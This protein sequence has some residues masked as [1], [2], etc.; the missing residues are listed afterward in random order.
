MTFSKFVFAFLSVFFFYSS[1][2]A[3][4]KDKKYELT[5]YHI[6]DSHGAFYKS[7]TTQ[8]GGFASL[9]TMVQTERKLAHQDRRAFFLTSSGDV[10]TGTPESDLLKGKPDFLA[11]NLLKFD[12]MALGN[13]EFDHPWPHIAEQKSWV[14][15]PF[16][17]ANIHSRSLLRFPVIPYVILEKEGVKVAFLGLTTESTP[18]ESLPSNSVG[19]TF[20]PT[21]ETAKTW[22]P[23]LKQRADIVVI[24]S[25]IGWCVLSPCSN[26]NDNLLAREVPDIDIIL[27]GHSHTDMDEARIENGVI[28][29]HPF[30]KLQKV[31][32]L[33]IEFLNGEVLYK[34]SSLK[35]IDAPEDE[36]VLEV[37]NGFL[38]EG[39]KI[40]DT[41][42]GYSDV[43]LNGERPDVRIQETNLANLI[44]HT[45][46][47]RTKADVVVINSGAIRAGI[48]EGPVTYGDIYKVLPFGNEVCT[49]D[50]NGA[51]LFAYLSKIA[52]MLPGDGN[53][54]HI[55]GVELTTNTSN[56]ITFIRINGKVL[57]KDK[58]YKIAMNEYMAEGGDF[59]PKVDDKPTFLNTGFSMEYLLRNYFEV[60]PLVTDNEIIKVKNYYKRHASH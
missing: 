4:I 46:E 56:E 28:V 22:V 12:A 6:S 26:P 3:Y 14:G 23:F 44:T 30:E 55:R 60:N 36:T 27:G 35:K 20:D 33:N 42:V 38:E 47:Q 59:Y 58:V 39:R 51:E 40:L 13:H 11:M 57:K 9:A 24:L 43:F 5:F 54:P 7:P 49:L 50:L 45:V 29:L 15:F 32:V 16:L 8:L 31:A 37:M 1:S 48:L 34:N 41:R 53:F 18:F 19:L 10:N 17:S 25:H 21:I 52:T 2:N